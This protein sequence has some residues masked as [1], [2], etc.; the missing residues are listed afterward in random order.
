MKSYLKPRNVCSSDS[1]DLYQLLIANMDVDLRTAL[2]HFS[3]F[4]LFRVLLLECDL[5]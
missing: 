2:L 1:E 3:H 4:M 5:K